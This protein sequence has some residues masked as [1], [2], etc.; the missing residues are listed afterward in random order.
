MPK[1]YI[2]DMWTFIICGDRFKD[3]IG[4]SYKG[5]Q[6]ALISRKIVNP[7]TALMSRSYLLC[8]SEL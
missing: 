4:H 8:K 6:I 7:P 3:R 5:N 1:V 2:V